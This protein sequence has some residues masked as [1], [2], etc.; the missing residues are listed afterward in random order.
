MRKI[1]VNEE[2]FEEVI[3]KL[4][5]I[6][7]KYKMLE[8]YRVFDG[9]MKEK[10]EYRRNA[11][12]FRNSIVKSNNPKNRYGYKKIKKLVYQNNYLR[13]TKH[14]FREQFERG[15]DTYGAKHHYPHMKSLIHI[16]LAG[17]RALVISDGDKIQF[18]PFGGFIIWE[19]DK[20]NLKNKIYFK[21]IFIP[22]RIKG[23]ILDLNQ[24][25]DIRDK[26][27]EEEANW[28]DEHDVLNEDD[29][30]DLYASC[31]DIPDYELENNR[32]EVTD[33]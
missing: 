14:S 20:L 15:E 1:I 11:I 16:D 3:L 8:F 32:S 28:W 19:D 29:L 22:D 31:E 13:L 30:Y 33:I 9:E 24:E 26:E 25:N 5:N 10:K 17:G 7:N 6:C 12:C 4:Q 21:Y 18:L 2:N 23:K 27:W